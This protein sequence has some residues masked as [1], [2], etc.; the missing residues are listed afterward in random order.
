MNRR[1]HNRNKAVLPVRVCGSDATGTYSDLAHTLDIAPSGARLGSIHRLH[2]V[3][4]L[5]TI[6]YR[7]HRMQFRVIWTK[8]LCDNGLEHQIG[9]ET[10]ERGRDPLWLQADPKLQSAACAS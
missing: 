9:L 1:T 10:V 8:T 6:Q 2:R 3:G 7:Q 5:I 4:E